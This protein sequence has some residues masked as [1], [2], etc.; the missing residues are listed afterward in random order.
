MNRELFAKNSGFTRKALVMA[1]IDEY[2]RPEYLTR[3]FKDSMISGAKIVSTT[4]TIDP[5]RYNK[6][7]Q[8]KNIND[9]QTTPDNTYTKA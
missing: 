7:I 4:K 8:D 2:S 5:A 3:I 1:S 6:V 9:I